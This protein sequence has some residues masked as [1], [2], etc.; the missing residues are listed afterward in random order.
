VRPLTVGFC[1]PQSFT[2]FSWLIMWAYSIPYDHVYVKIEFPEYSR[3]VVY[4]ASSVAVNFETL[5]V[6][7]ANVSVV[8]EFQVQISDESYA[9]L[10]QFAFDN[11]GKPYGYLECVG[12]GLVKLAS[13]FGKTIK[14]PLGSN[15]TTYVCSQL[16][17]CILEDFAG[18][19]LPVDLSD[20]TPKDVFDYLSQLKS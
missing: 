18:A 14:N 1:K 17:G 3:T 16:A 9:K 11:V 10:I 7:T 13:V 4:Q 12:L 5:S 19:N 2:P 8:D 6:F 15:Q 20:I